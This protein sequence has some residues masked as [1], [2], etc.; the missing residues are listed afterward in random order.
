MCL[1][2][3]AFERRFREDIS[4]LESAAVLDLVKSDHINLVGP[5]CIRFDVELREVVR[6]EP[7][8]SDP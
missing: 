4:V 6:K 2:L 3:H 5:V 7:P 1:T 8:A